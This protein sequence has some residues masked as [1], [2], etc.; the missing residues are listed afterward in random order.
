MAEM[1]EKVTRDVEYVLLN[2][3]P[4]S[5]KVKPSRSFFD[6]DEDQRKMAEWDAE[7]EKQRQVK[8]TDMYGQVM[9]DSK[10]ND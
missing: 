4:S 9:M 7:Q 10:G 1:E 2:Q 3:K 6:F 5:M 8:L